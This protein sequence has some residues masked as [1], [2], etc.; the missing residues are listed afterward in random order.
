MACFAKLTSS[1]PYPISLRPD[2]GSVAPRRAASFWRAAT[3]AALGKLNG[4]PADRIVSRHWGDDAGASLIVKAATAPASSSTSGELLALS[5]TGRSPAWRQ[6]AAARLFAACS[7][8]DFS[9]THQV[10]IPAVA[11]ASPIFVGE[12]KLQSL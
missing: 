7:R 12:A 9:S 6:S 5:S 10:I 3:A 11:T 4:E 2:Y 1:K 8:I